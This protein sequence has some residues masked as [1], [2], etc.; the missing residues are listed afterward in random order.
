MAEVNR[1]PHPAGILRRSPHRMTSKIPEPVTLN[2]PANSL[3]DA[4]IHVVLI[5]DHEA[6]RYLVTFLMERHGFVMHSAVDGPSGI[7]L[8]LKLCPALILLDIQL[9]LMDGYEVARQLRSHRSLANTPIV[10]ITS[11]AMAG[12]RDRVLNCGCSGY[13]EKPI[14]PETFVT[15]LRSYLRERS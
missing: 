8:A 1:L 12:D 15:T 13:I 10:A 3:A 6:N 9:P 7:E 11:Y 4:P 2:P 5:E 14:D